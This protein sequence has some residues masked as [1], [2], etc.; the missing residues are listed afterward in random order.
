MYSFRSP[1]QLPSSVAT[2]CLS[3]LNLKTR[4]LQTLDTFNCFNVVQV[5]KLITNNFRVSMIII[6]TVTNNT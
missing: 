3:E 6:I 5:N 2:S 4:H 1:N